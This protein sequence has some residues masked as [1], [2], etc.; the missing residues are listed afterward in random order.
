M[1]SHSN[2]LTTHREDLEKSGLNDQ[3]IK[4]MG[5]R[6]LP[7]SEWEQFLG[8]RPSQ[9]TL[10]LLAFPYPNTNGFCRVK[11]FPPLVNSEGR[12]MKYLQ[13]TGSGV[14]LYT[15][16]PVTELITNAYKPLYFTEGEKKAAKATQEN[17]PCVGIGGLWNWIDRR[18]G[19]GIAE[20]DRIAWVDR[21]VIFIPDSDIWTRPDLQRAVYAFGKELEG[22]GT[23]F[24]VTVIPQ[25]GS[26]KVGLDDFLIKHTVDEL[27]K[28]KRLTL[29]HSS[30]KQHQ[31][32]WKQWKR[33]KANQSTGP[34]KSDLVD[35]P[36]G[37]TLQDI[38]A[39]Q[40]ELTSS[41]YSGDVLEI[42]LAVAASLA[43]AHRDGT[44]P[45][46]LL[47]VGVPS[48]D[49]TEC[50]SAMKSTPEVYFLDTLTENSFITGYLDSAGHPVMDLLPELD[51]KCLVVK[52]YTTLFSMKDETIKKILG[53]MQSIYDGAFAKFTGTRGL[54]AY[55]AMFSHIGCITP[56]ALSSHHRYMAMIGSRFLFYRTLP[57]TQKQQSEGLEKIWNTELRRE[58]VERLRKLA[59]GLLHELLSQEP[60][61][62]IES[63]QQREEINN[64]AQLLSRGR[65][66]ITTKK[67]TYENKEGKQ[68][69]SY[70]VDEI[71]TE[72]PFRAAMQLRSL[73]RALAWVHGRDRMT[74][75][76][77]ELLR[78]VVLSTMPVDRASV[79]ALF[80]D[81]RNL[82]PGYQGLT[83]KQCSEG[84]EKSYNRAIQLLIELQQV[85]ILD[86]CQIKENNVDVNL[87]TPF[88]EFHSIIH[89]SVL[90]LDHSADLIEAVDVDKEDAQN[91]EIEN[92]D[93]ENWDM[94]N[95]EI[96]NEESENWD[97]ENEEIDTK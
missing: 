49:K 65:A 43:I 26:E 72:E 41:P 36:N 15:L 13:P 87:Y 20:L 17:L 46:W 54:V 53:D 30:L 3:T 91:E 66:V 19:E 59:S 68:I 2:L 16:P 67:T 1:T 86:M 70:E 84:I 85:K 51:G 25:D 7:P 38:H 73:G 23:R 40:Q 69:S 5:V 90:P 96:E 55:E 74:S 77:I 10:S 82:K 39:V 58:T 8:W 80:Q 35:L 45:V 81:M 37:V 48:S 92:G 62:F 29:K 27:E 94:E 32:W 9:E 52:D 6:T 60:P 44:P 76:E 42:S 28:L 88:P 33:A 11:A 78:R 22:R 79:P 12:R 24:F 47:C 97:I 34:A 95:E 56:L 75:H 57:L 31:N 61:K 89:H 18:T 71:Q 93:M 83:R 14:H 63:T 50:V 4:L 21:E 64:F